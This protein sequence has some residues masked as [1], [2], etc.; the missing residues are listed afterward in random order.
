MKNLRIVRISKSVAIDLEYRWSA[1]GLNDRGD[2]F[3]RYAVE[4]SD[5][6]RDVL[7]ALNPDKPVGYLT[8]L[9]QSGYPPFRRD[10]VPEINDFNV[11]PSARRFGVGTALMDEA[12]AIIHERGSEAGIGVGLYSDYGPAQQMYVRRGYVPDGLGVTSHAN[13]VEPGQSVVVD[14]ELIPWF[15][16]R[17]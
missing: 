17:L 4:Q 2:L 1:E 5:G 3:D 9:W 16:K 10:K 12:E 7:I 11:F 8:V 13:K 6:T 14:D 15:R